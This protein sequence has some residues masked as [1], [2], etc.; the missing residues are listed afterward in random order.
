MVWE[1]NGGR[2]YAPS[3]DG[4]L[5]DLLVQNKGSKRSHNNG[6]KLD[7]LRLRSRQEYRIQGGHLQLRPPLL[8]PVVALEQRFQNVIRTS[9]GTVLCLQCAL[10]YLRKHPILLVVHRGLQDAEHQLHS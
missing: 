7:Y 8:I 3:L 4:E 1:P 6:C 9:S 10:H 2:R 5:P